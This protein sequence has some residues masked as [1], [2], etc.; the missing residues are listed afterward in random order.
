[1]DMGVLRTN[2]A[3]ASD[4]SQAAVTALLREEGP[5]VLH[6]HASA[7]GPHGPGVI[8]GGAIA[9]AA[10]SV[11]ELQAASAGGLARVTADFIRPAPMEPLTI[12]TRRLRQGRRVRLDQARVSGHGAEVAVISAL[13]LTTSRAEPHQA[14]WPD[15][16][17]LPD[18]STLTLIRAWNDGFFGGAVECRTR[19]GKHRVGAGCC[20]ARLRVPVVEGHITSAAIAALALADIAQG[21]GAPISTASPVNPDLTVSLARDPCGSW[22]NLTV[23]EQWTGDSTGLAVPNLSDN[24]GML[25]V[26]LQAQVLKP[27]IGGSWGP[28]SVGRA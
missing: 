12:E 28:D 4:R 11:L 25:G 14:R 5:A 27:G 9:G 21:V 15:T 7:A 8:A 20:L 23:S 26:A 18:P 24:K 2:A 17:G 3:A 13:W 19:T 16:D 6:R 10:L 22:L 1:M